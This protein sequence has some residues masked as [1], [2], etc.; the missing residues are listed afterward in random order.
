M[1]SLPCSRDYS[2]SGEYVYGTESGEGLAYL[3]V[4]GTS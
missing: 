4:H 1:R 3:E 2:V